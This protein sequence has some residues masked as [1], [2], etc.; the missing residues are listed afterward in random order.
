MKY[1]FLLLFFVSI[2]CNGQLKVARSSINSSGGIMSSEE[3]KLSSSVGQSSLVN[4]FKNE[5]F[6]LRQGFQQPVS[7][8]GKKGD[9]N[10]SVYPNPNA[11]NF[12]L[13]SDDWLEGEVRIQLFDAT[14][15]LCYSSSFDSG[16]QFNVQTNK[17]LSIGLYT[18]RLMNQT[19]VTSHKL[20]IRSK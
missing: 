2:N 20:L 10:I 15:K 18:L 9:L 8:Q 4:T 1:L 17:S 19:T 11:G 5:S 3:I 16:R 6:G 7:I 12:T 13:I 14:G